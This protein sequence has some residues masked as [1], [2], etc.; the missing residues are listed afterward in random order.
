M[1]SPPAILI[2]RRRDPS[3]AAEAVLATELT[4]L[5]P[6]GTLGMQ[7]YW[8]L[9]GAVLYGAGF[10]SGYFVRAIVSWRRR[11]RFSRRHDRHDTTQMP[12]RF[13]RPS[14][15]SELPQANEEMPLRSAGDAQAPTKVDFAARRRR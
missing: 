9:I 6:P 15:P 2:A 12:M 4:S 3:K 5:S 8:L 13:L 10:L 1:Y 11:R 14:S 7:P